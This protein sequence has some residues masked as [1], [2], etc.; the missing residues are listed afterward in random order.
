MRVNSPRL[1]ELLNVE[2]KVLDKGFIRVVEY[3]GNDSSIVQSARVSYGEGTKTKRKDEGLIAYLIRHKHTTPFEM[4]EIKLHVKAPMFV[5][6][7]WLRHRTASVNE[8]SARYSVMKDEFYVPNAENIRSQGS[9]NKQSSG[10]SLS[11][12]IAE[13]IIRDM[14]LINYDLYKKYEE[15]ISMG[16]SRE[17]ARMILPANI[18]TEFY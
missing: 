13:E 9:S 3:M 12:V 7:Q 16:M 11:W 4:C 10:E 1:D 17:Q 6:R 18:Y 2:L 15:F 5:T 8:Y 14:K